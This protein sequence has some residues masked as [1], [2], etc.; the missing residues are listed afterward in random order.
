[1]LKLDTPQFETSMTTRTPTSC[2]VAK[3]IIH[4]QQ[5]TMFTL[6]EDS[7]K[8]HRFYVDVLRYNKTET[9]ISIII[10]KF[11]PH[12]VTCRFDRGQNIMNFGSKNF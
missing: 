2:V 7:I 12:F 4:Y 10:E 5:T 6:F 9:G 1:M 8:Y 3:Y 11:S